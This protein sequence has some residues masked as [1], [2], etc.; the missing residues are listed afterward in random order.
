MEVRFT[1]HRLSELAAP[2]P[3]TAHERSVLQFLVRGS[4]AALCQVE[5]ADVTEECVDQCGSLV[6]AVAPGACAPI[7][8]GNGLLA[9][10]EWRF[11]ETIHEMQDVLL[12]VRD[13]NISVLETYRGDAEVPSGL[14]QADDLTMLWGV[15]GAV[16]WPDADSNKDV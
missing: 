14:P 12:F 10:A 5:N 6:M 16:P 8:G 1:K 9:N 4:E 11:G 3:L 15:D 2:R 13:G 7:P